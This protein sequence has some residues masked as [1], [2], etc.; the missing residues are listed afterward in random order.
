MHSGER[1]CSESATTSRM[2]MISTTGED[3]V[4][5]KVQQQRKGN[6][7]GMVIVVVREVVEKREKPFK[8]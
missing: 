4:A 5:E 1:Y 6:V 3:G 2:K 7:D 8:V